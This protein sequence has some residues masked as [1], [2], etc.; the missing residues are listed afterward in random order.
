[1]TK[2]NVFGENKSANKRLWRHQKSRYLVTN[3]G[4]R[5]SVKF[6]VTIFVCFFELEENL[7]NLEMLEPNGHSSSLVIWSKSIGSGLVIWPYSGKW[8]ILTIYLG[9]WPRGPDRLL[10]PPLFGLKPL[11]IWFPGPLG[12]PCWAFG[13]NSELQRVI[14]YDSLIEF[15]WSIIWRLETAV[16]ILAILLLILIALLTMIL[17]WWLAWMIKYPLTLFL[18]KIMMMGI[19][20]WWVSMWHMG[21]NCPWIITKS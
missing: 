16:I 20:S 1:M 4:S 3:K 13:I 6:H 19:E 18:V 7:N 10:K 9:P 8:P 17:E 15:T 11:I 12:A 2:N 14:F 21:W 5:V